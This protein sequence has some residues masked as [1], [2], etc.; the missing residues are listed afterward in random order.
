MDTFQKMTVKS[1]K[2]QLAS[3]KI[4]DYSEFIPRLQADSRRAVQKMGTA[5]EK[6]L[7]AAA[8]E[9]ARIGQ[10]KRLENS[11]Y[12]TGI[13]RIAGLDEVGR[14]PLAG[15]VVT[16]A[17]VMKADS[18]RLYV[19]DSKKLSKKMREQLS[20]QLL[21]D[22]LDYAIGIVDNEIIDQINILNATKKAMTDALAALQPPPELLLID[23]LELNT[24]IPQQA[25]I[26]GDATCYAIA[27]ASIVAKVYRDN[28]MQAYHQKYP[29][30]GFD[31]NMG[32]GTA[33]HIEA[34]K[35]FGPTPIHRKTFITNLVLR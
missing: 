13:R 7:L 19:N 29:E 11:F 8:A 16:C 35:K 1:I 4:Q 17:I 28:L 2:E 15:P 23:A 24:E 32:Y 31:H 21:D 3:L 14:G 5:L 34:I 6:K 22:A 9:T 18:Q 25:I 27:A 10:M 20:A 26:H 33:T 30:Y 12:A